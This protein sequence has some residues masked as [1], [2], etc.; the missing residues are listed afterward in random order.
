[1]V[2]AVFELMAEREGLVLVDEI[3]IE[4]EVEG[5]EM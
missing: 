1:V 5:L 4:V 3:E 2:E